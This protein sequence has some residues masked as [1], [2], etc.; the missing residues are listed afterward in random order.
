MIRRHF[1]P[2]RA[3][4]PLRLLLRVA[5]RAPRSIRRPLGRA[6]VAVSSDVR[7]EQP[8][9][10]LS[11]SVRAV[12]LRALGQ[13]GAARRFAVR[14]AASSGSATRFAMARFL[15]VV[16]AD[17]ESLEV[18]R[19]DRLP[20]DP[21]A[22]RAWRV[23]QA[24]K[25]RRLGR[26][27]EALAAID[28]ALRLAP[29]DPVLAGGAAGPWR[30]F[31]IASTTLPSIRVAG[32]SPGRRAVSCGWPTTG[33][34][35]CSR[36]TRSETSRPRLH[37]AMPAS[38]RMS[39]CSRARPRRPTECWKRRLTACHTNTW[40]AP[41]SLVG[42]GRRRATM[43][44]SCRPARSNASRLPR[45]T[46]RHRSWSVAPGWPLAAGSG[47]PSSTRSAAS[48]RKRGSRR[49]ASPGSTPTTTCSPAGQRRPACFAADAVVTLGEAM[50][51]EI[52]ARGVPA[53]RISV[54][55]NVVDSQRFAP[56]PRDSD[57]AR[58]LGIADHEVVVGYIS[59]FQPY[60]DFETFV[61]AI[62][63]APLARA[64]GPWAVGR[65]RGPEAGR[66]P[67][68]RRE[69]GPGRRGAA[70]GSR[71]SRFGPALLPP[72]RHLC[73]AASREP[74]R[75]PG[76]AAQAVRGDGQRAGR[77]WSAGSRRCSRSS[78]KAKPA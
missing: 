36:V 18:L 48:S 61:R 54:M 50:K 60:E 69:G 65:R 64:A 57:L 9:G 19:S 37:S 21:A 5:N 73:G 45:F 41:G 78:R 35:A 76:H 51:A 2:S 22:A 13:D 74:R 23:L 32:A 15:D 49:W 72:H 6:L 40:R 63:L 1:R 46:P 66:G 10:L 31:S 53:E 16:G 56:G 44:S 3:P 59:S 71:A 70:A 58:E 24:R 47:C 25:A 33:C 20:R 8:T 55:P 7:P 77:S 29:A 28:D 67:P 12:G 34:R 43:S 52:V 38:T 26:Y 4:D 42:R 68:A 14:A 17:A 27:R 30:R 39:W 62:E 11:A 75:A